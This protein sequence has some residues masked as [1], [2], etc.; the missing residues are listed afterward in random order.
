ML[1][2]IKTLKQLLEP[3]A[4]KLGH[5]F[6]SWIENSVDEN[7]RFS[8][9]MKEYSKKVNVEKYP[10]MSFMSSMLY[11]TSDLESV[12]DYLKENY[13]IKNT[14]KYSTLFKKHL[15]KVINSDQTRISYWRNNALI[16]TS[17]EEGFLNNR[18]SFEPY[19]KLKFKDLSNL[20]KE[21]GLKPLYHLEDG[22]LSIILN[23]KGY[24]KWLFTPEHPQ[25]A[26]NPIGI[27]YESSQPREYVDIKMI[28]ALYFDYIIKKWI[29]SNID[30]N[31]DIAKKHRSKYGSYTFSVDISRKIV[32]KNREEFKGLY[33]DEI[34]SNNIDLYSLD[35]DIPHVTT[36][37]DLE[38]I[39][40]HFNNFKEKIKRMVDKDCSKLY[41]QYED[42][43]IIA[44]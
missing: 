33:R 38:L 42:D 39:I 30:E 5:T 3:T 11:F 9:F 15:S 41:K 13:Y 18:S 24:E 44:K 19:T 1:L 12:E 23:D 17:K 4:N 21:V 2:K 27:G 6:E 36:K 25:W 29:R 26:F 40:Q 10:K 28:Y 31:S 32:F 35:F 20:F 8:F 34:D 14:N 16:T 7:M 43:K 22:E 37:E